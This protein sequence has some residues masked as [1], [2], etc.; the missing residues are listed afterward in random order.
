[1]N[2]Q[3]K[4]LALFKAHLG[5]W[6]SLDTISEAAGIHDWMRQLRMLRQEG[7]QI[8][9]QG[10][11]ESTH[12]RL[13]SAEKQVGHIRDPISPKLRA[14]I[15]NRDN[16]RCVHCGRSPAEDGVKLHIDHKIPIDWDGPPTDPK[17]LQTLCEECNQGKQAFFAD[18]DAD[19]DIKEVLKAESGI[20]RLRLLGTKVLNK[21]LEPDFIATI[22]RVRDWTRIIRRL[23]EEGKINYTYNRKHDR[24][25]FLPL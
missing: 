12:Y 14:K 5:E 20:E 11:R 22:S 1:M 17:N 21:P 19:E 23:K 2:A 16:H 8:E 24:Y 15:L 10:G 3:E 7:W 13:V 4:M 6:L 18:F 9:K 25:T